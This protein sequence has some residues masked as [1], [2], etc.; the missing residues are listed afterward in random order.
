MTSL[1]KPPASIPAQFCFRILWVSPAPG[2]R[3]PGRSPIRPAPCLAPEGT[4]IRW[5][6]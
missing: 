5:M 1:L 6:D 3:G 2:P 4:R